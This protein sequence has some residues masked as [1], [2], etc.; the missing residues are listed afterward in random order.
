MRS[1]RPSS[2]LAAT[3]AVT[4]FAGCASSSPVL[5]TA[6][7]LREMTDLN[8]LAEFP[9]PPFVCRQFSS[10]DRESKSPSENWFANNDRG[11]FLRVEKRDDRSEY[12]MMDADGRRAKP[13][14]GDLRARGQT[15]IIPRSS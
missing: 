7:L 9:D 11:Q 8:A 5:T 12:V 1:L 3:V 6:S 15:M 4:V 14:A 2:R 13:C 10:Y